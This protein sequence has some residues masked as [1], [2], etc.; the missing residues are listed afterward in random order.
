MV[1]LVYA[2]VVLLF[3][4]VAGFLIN[5]VATRLAADKPMFGRLGCTR[6][7][8]PI[9]LLEAFP[10]LGYLLQRGRCSTCSKKLSLAYP[11]TEG[12]TALIFILLFALEGLSISFFFHAAY[13]ALLMLVLV[14]DWKH[15]DIYL[16]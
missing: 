12:A 10:V 13:T 5:V 7:S 11:L 2:L 15:R 4:L 1:N 3:G 6:S 14:M 16:S 9:S 8:H